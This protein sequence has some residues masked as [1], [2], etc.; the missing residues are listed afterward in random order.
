MEAF[1]PR[2]PR[3]RSGGSNDTGLQ[4][5]QASIRWDE[6]KRHA[7][8]HRPAAR[9]RELTPIVSVQNRYN[10]IDRASQDVLAECQRQGI[11]FIPWF[12]LATGKLAT[13][14]G[15]LAQTAERHHA[16]PAQIALAWLLHRSE[17][18]LPIPGTASVEHLEENV[19]A[20]GIQLS[21]DEVRA[22]ELAAED[23]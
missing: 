21:T 7:P 17:V 16:T 10:L 13:G 23:G 3:R 1:E 14:G 6:R 9:G 4:R 11:G 8:D 22:L 18:M 2:D 15:P 19:A 20:A 12:P 5:E